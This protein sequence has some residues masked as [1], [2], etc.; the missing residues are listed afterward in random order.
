MRTNTYKIA[1]SASNENLDFFI[2]DDTGFSYAGTHLTIDL[3]GASGLD[4]LPLIR[5]TLH[6]CAIESGATILH[7]HLHYFTPN[8]G[9]SG[10]VVLSESHISIHTWPERSFAALDIFMCGTAQPKKAI[11]VL[12]TAFTPTQILLNELKRG[13]QQDDQ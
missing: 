12:K 4:N 13:I 5:N 1:D 3:W 8:G 9:V 7:S 10:V 11:P 2:Y 6:Q